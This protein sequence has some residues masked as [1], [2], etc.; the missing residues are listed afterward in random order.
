[1]YNNQIFSTQYSASLNHLALVLA[2]LNDFNQARLYYL[3]AIKLV[4]K[5]IKKGSIYL[6]DDL[7]VYKNNLSLLYF[8]SKKFKK[9][10]K[11]MEQTYELIL[12]SKKKNKRSYFK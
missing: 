9:C 7:V 1:E 4:S 2:D 6:L 12:G 10:M 5:H 3:Q 11:E 8:K